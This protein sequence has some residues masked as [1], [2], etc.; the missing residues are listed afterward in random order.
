MYPQAV[1]HRQTQIWRIEVKQQPFSPAIQIITYPL[2]HL[3]V[4][5]G[6]SLKQ[7]LL[8][9][10]SLLFQSVC[11]HGCV[12]VCACVA[13]S[14][15]KKGPSFSRKPRPWRWKNKNRCLWLPASPRSPPLSTHL[16]TLWTSSFRIRYKTTA[17]L[18]LLIN[19]HNCGKS[20]PCNKTLNINTWMNEWIW[21]LVVLLFWLY[22]V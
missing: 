17:L 14:R 12:C 4:K 5:Q 6:L 9:L 3:V 13:S 7:L 19:S 10:I 16:L 22:F 8:P 2:A 20:N 21:L 15:M 1:S 18:C 11:V